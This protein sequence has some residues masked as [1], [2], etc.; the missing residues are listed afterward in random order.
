MG[1][2]K[3]AT[4]AMICFFFYSCTTT[5]HH[6]Y[7]PS[8]QKVHV[9]VQCV[10]VCCVLCYCG[11]DVLYVPIVQLSLLTSAR[12]TCTCIYLFIYG[13]GSICWTVFL[14]LFTLV[15][16]YTQTWFCWHCC[17]L[18]CVCGSPGACAVV[19]PQHLCWFIKILKKNHFLLI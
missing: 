4:L 8:Q 16:W 11:C 19:R 9:V 7:A 3:V 14:R 10:C 18:L 5:P 1:R 17:N 2:C 13:C 6:L 12:C 15:R